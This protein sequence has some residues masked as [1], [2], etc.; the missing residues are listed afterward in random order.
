M[1][2]HVE[3]HGDNRSLSEIAD[4]LRDA[5]ERLV[6][7]SLRE[8]E[9]SE[10]AGREL[11][12][13][14]AVLHALN[15]GVLI[16]DSDAR[17]VMLN[18][19][20]RH[21]MGLSP[22]VQ[23]PHASALELR[24]LDMTALPPDALPLQRALLG[25]PYPDSELLL[26]RES[27][28]TRRV[29]VCST[30]TEEAHRVALAVIVLRDVTERRAIEAHLAQTERLA[31]IGALAAGVAHEVNN[32]LTYVTT[33]LELLLEEA[34]SYGDH[35][36]PEQLREL[37]EM[38]REAQ[39]GAERI[40]KI[41]GGL[42]T[43]SRIDEERHAV[44]DLRPVLE[45]AINMASNEIRHRARLVKEAGP[46]PL[47]A[48]DEA[49]L[50]QVFVNL[51]V[52]A[53]HSFS[54]TVS[55]GNEVVVST[56]TDARGR[57]VIEIRDT[58]AGISEAALPHIFD[59]FFTTKAIGVGTG[60]GLSICHNIVTA[61]GGELQVASVLGQGTTFRLS[62]LPAQDAP[63]KVVAP[64]PSERVPSRRAEVLVIDDEPFI[65]TVMKRVLADHAVT[66]V[67]RV[68][69]A[70]ALFEAGRS[71][72]VI[73]SDLMMPDKGG[74]QLHEALSRTHPE[75]ARR[76][77]F[78]TGGAFTPSAIAF[79]ERVPNE[80]LDKPIDADVVR[81][82]VRRHLDARGVPEYTTIVGRE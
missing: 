1:P 4:E 48:A 25:Q 71:F 16:V 28:E 50:G 72:D 52:N 21:I 39:H 59:P 56:F 13:L 61:M 15:E 67:G 47:V 68:D 81:R 69:E 9:S 77:V 26:V 3:A 65:G 17:I 10:A 40:R 53:A 73:L 46:V 62:L 49:R 8:Q 55:E 37:T 19:A 78:M 43:F 60:L 31:A 66:F 12:R 75:Q 32:P 70:V 2:R 74:M 42:K 33:N 11:A 24:N 79:L 23:A 44:I 36:S 54:D 27:G 57:A 64:A 20:A 6:L 45:L 18:D 38:L 5:N 63:T 30:F 22:S 41:V 51:L 14:S 35:P 7:T 80:R 82:M 34:E 29:V 58:G 76:I